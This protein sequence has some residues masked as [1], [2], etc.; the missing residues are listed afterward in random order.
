MM[1]IEGTTDGFIKAF[2]DSNH[3][4]ETDTHFRNQNG[5]C[6]F[7]YRLLFK[8]NHPAKSDEDYKLKIQAYDRDFF[9][10]NDLIGEGTIDLRPVIR[11]SEIAVRPMAIGKDYYDEYLKP[12]CGWP[13]LKFHSDQQSFWIKMMSKNEKGVLECNGEVRIQIDVLPLADALKNRVG[14]AREEPNV[15]PYLPMPTGRLEL[16]LNPLKMLEQ[17]VGPGFRKKMYLFICIA[18]CITILVMLFPMIFSDL[19]SKGILAMFGLS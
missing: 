12:E 14:E 17:L 13:D 8:F 18:L 6:S 7:N 11:D 5:E 4:K 3:A 19:I 2:F 1:D 10:S 16:S 15:N 9:K